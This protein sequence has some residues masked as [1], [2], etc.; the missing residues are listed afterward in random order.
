MTNK[1]QE[2]AIEQRQALRSTI[3]AD[4]PNREE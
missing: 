4:E 3:L 1:D 2:E